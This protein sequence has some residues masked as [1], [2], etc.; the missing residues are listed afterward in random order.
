MEKINNR[1]QSSL[2]HGKVFIGKSKVIL[3][4]LLVVFSFFGVLSLCAII[5][6]LAQNEVKPVPLEYVYIAIVGYILL[7]VLPISVVIWRI[8]FNNRLVKKIEEWLKDSELLSAKAR[9]LT[10]SRYS[11][12]QIELKFYYNGKKQKRISTAGNPIIGYYKFFSES[13]KK[14]DILYSAK[15]DEVLI[16]KEES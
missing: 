16:L 2:S 12:K 15:Y 8:I 6:F 4:I 5:M 13:E 11:S 14:L 3:N 9:R 1:I 7:F 10:N